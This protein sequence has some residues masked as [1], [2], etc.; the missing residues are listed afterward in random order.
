MAATAQTQL[1]VELAIRLLLDSVSYSNALPPWF[2]T[3]TIDYSARERRIR[4]EIDRYEKGS[5]ANRAFEVSVP[6][7]SGG[8]NTWIVPSI[9]DQIICQAFIS[10]F[11]HQLEQTTLDRERVF[12]VLLNANPTRLAFLEDQ[13]QA[14]SR[15]HAFTQQRCSTSDCMLQIDIKEAFRNIKPQNVFDFAKKKV[16]RSS[17]ASTP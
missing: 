13:V 3:L 7:R 8:N 10:S 2:E 14:W 11:A 1:P 12:G 5:N 15:F 4:Q 9:N 17:G 16:W 6:K